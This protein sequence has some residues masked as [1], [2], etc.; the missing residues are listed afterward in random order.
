MPDPEIALLPVGH[1]ARPAAARALWASIASAVGF[2]AFAA[3]TTQVHAIRVGSP[4]QDDPYNGVVSLTQFFVPMLAVA[5]VARAA[6]CRRREPQP[7]FR[8]DQLLRAA[9]VVTLLAAVTVAVDWLAVALRADRRLWDQ[10]TSWLIIALVPLTAAL[11]AS[12]LL[13]RLAFRRLP[14]RDRG[15]PDGDWL[16]DLGS[17]V[18]GPAVIGIVR[19]HIVALTVAGSVVAGL[20]VTAA[21]AISEGWTSPVLF[22]T[23]TAAVAGGFFALALLSVIVLQV[24][25]P[26][27]DAM[28]RPT[29][30]LRRAAGTAALIGFISLPVSAVLRAG[31][32]TAIG[33]TGEVGSPIRLMAVTAVSAL[34]AASLAFAVSVSI[35]PLTIVR[36]NRIL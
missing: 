29:G 28:R 31:I 35:S 32:W 36:R 33:Q 9:F 3:L 25:V 27:K 6:L 11:T 30:R 10:G 20:L 24:A 34:V 12:L 21:Q 23:M 5:V 8:I 7:M 17:V 14:S 18:H 15:R 22:L 4:W 13:Q 2:T 16:D 1:G 19:D 26:R